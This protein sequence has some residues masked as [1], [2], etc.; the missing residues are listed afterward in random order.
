MLLGLEKEIGSLEV[1]KRADLITIS[2]AHP[3]AVPLYNL[4]SHL[5]YATKAGDVEDV[6]INGRQIVRS[7]QPLTLNAPAIYGKAE[8]Y[9]Q[10]ILTSIKQ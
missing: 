2:L 4:Y 10:Q 7:R 3:N 1:G 6:F 8:N 9:R 5:A